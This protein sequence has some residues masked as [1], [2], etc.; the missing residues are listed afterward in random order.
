[1]K[2]YI[3]A[4]MVA[5]AAVVCS[6]GEAEAAPKRLKGSGNIITKELPAP[7][8]YRSVHASRSVKV[9]LIANEGQPVKIKADDNVMEHVVVAVNGGVLS[10]TISDKVRTIASVN[11]TVTVPCD[12]KLS[13]LKAAS[14]GQI[15]S[16]VQI[17]GEEVELQASSAGEIKGSILATECDID[18][19]SA[20]KIYCKVGGSSCSID[21]SSA[22][23]CTA[24]LA[25]QECE[26]DASSAAEVNLKGATLRC[27][28]DLSSAAELNAKNFAVENYDID[29]SSAADATIF[30]TKRLDAEASSGGYIRYSGNCQVSSKRSSGG[31]IKSY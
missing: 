8:H 17:K 31:T 2:S 11:V 5:V 16:E 3:I 1:M 29:V 23:I 21:A 14:A 13:S 15:H 28:A 6:S 26:V 4:L 25:V 22:A 9:N 7:T 18:L 19:S 27:D 30:C 24:T 12:G 20:A 10:V